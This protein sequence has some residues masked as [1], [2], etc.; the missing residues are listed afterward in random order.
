[1]SKEPIEFA[2][3]AGAKCRIKP[4]CKKICRIQALIKLTYMKY[5]IEILNPKAS[6][7]LKNLADMQLITIT[8]M[9]SSDPFLNVVKRIRKKA[10]LKPL[11]LEEI[12]KEV[13]AVRAKRYAKNKA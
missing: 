12:T 2:N 4:L 3:S 5:Q 8:E 11:A 6:K 10:S 7:L 13:E 1:M 9:P